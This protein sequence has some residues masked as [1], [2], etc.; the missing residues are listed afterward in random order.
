MYIVYTICIYTY[1]CI[2]LCF[3]I[4][5]S[6]FSLGVSLLVN[7]LAVVLVWIVRYAGSF[8]WDLSSEIGSEIVMNRSQDLILWAGFFFSFFF[9][10]RINRGSDC[11]SAQ[12]RDSSCYV[13]RKARTWTGI[14]CRGWDCGEGRIECE[15]RHL[16][17]G[18]EWIRIRPCWRV[19]ADLSGRRRSTE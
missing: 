7:R 6:S 10:Q 11:S 2:F 4:R 14:Y 16:W 5:I 9:F 8:R 18:D 19:W 15:E 3:A 17:M 13:N 1:I 12:F